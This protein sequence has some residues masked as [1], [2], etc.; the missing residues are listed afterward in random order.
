MQVKIVSIT[1]SLIE[2]QKLSPEELIV[3]IARVS[4]P[5]NQLNTETSDKLIRYLIKNRHWSPFEMVDLGV[6]VKTSRAIA[7][8]ILRHWSIHFQ[9]F[10]QRYAEVVEM[11]P[12]QLRKQAE[13]NRQSSEEEF[14][15]IIEFGGIPE[16]VKTLLKECLWYFNSIP[17]TR[18]D[19][20]NTKDS[21]EVASRID[22]YLR[23]HPGTMLTS[24]A[25]QMSIDGDV[26]LYKKLLKAQIAKECARMILPLTTQTTLYMKATVRDW[27]H[28]LIARTDK[29]AQLEHRQLANAIAPIF[30]SQFPNV[31]KALNNV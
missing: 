27:I 3:Y 24:E 19:S 15:P 13:S 20:P 26:D 12:V 22:T 29:H 17:R 28:Y 4:N 16:D 30:E 9:E 8:Q 7:A 1:S 5:S 18:A 23:T 31:V 11:E 2:E 25:V 10:S 6:E 14:D 21:Y